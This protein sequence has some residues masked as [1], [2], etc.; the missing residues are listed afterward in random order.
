MSFRRVMTAAAVS[1]AAAVIATS[2]IASAA[3]APSPGA[4]QL[5]GDRLESALLPVSFFGSGYARYGGIFSSGNQL[6]STTVYENIAAMSCS[7]F[8]GEF[9]ASGYGETSLV[10]D[11]IDDVNL[12]QDYDQI[13]YQF[14]SP[15][16]AS[17]FYSAEY[18]KYAK[19]RAFEEPGDDPAGITQSVIT[20]K[21]AGHHAFLVSQVVHE[22]DNPTEYYFL[23]VTDGADVFIVQA[24]DVSNTDP[25]DPSPST[26]ITKLI[27]RVSALR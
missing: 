16:A 22:P 4:I 8:W 14:A 1:A 2:S 23:V 26:V 19:C 27:S 25:G 21:V 18:K 6:E 20:K 15:P 7:A 10:T 13:I 12:P 3:P 5:T 17:S 24:L 9:S 11:A